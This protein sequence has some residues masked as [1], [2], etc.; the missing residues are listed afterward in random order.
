MRWRPV[1]APWLCRQQSNKGAVYNTQTLE[2]VVVLPFRKGRPRSCLKFSRN[3]RLVAVCGGGC[4][5]Q[6]SSGG[7]ETFVRSADIDWR[8]VTELDD[9]FAGR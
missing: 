4:W 7:L 5:S 1:V 3:W 2:L 6:R 9:Q 8:S